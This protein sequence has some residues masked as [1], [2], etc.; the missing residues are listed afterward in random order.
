[1]DVTRRHT[2]ALQFVLRGAAEMATL[3]KRDKRYHIRFNI[4]GNKLNRKRIS[5]NFNPNVKD[6]ECAKE[7]AIIFAEKIQ[8]LIDFVYHKKDYKKPYITISELYNY[9]NRDM[10]TYDKFVELKEVIE[11]S[12]YIELNKHFGRIC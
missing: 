8:N 3:E 5:L 4:C 9:Y 12:Y 7:R 1:M 11:K 10:I 2:R 6:E